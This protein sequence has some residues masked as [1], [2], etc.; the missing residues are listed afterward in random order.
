[1][2]KEAFGWEHFEDGAVQA[3]RFAIGNPNR[4]A[5]INLAEAEKIH[6]QGTRESGNEDS[7]QE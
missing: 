4:Y 5:L 1:M 6:G 2:T 3:L 7:A